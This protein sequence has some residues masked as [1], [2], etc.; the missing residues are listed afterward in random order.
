MQLLVDTDAFCKLAVG[1]VFV[2][3]IGLVGVS[4]AECGR[5]APLPHMLR[6]GILRRNYGSLACD[7]LIPVAE[8]IP[9]A[10]QPTEA[11]LD[12]LVPIRAIDPGEAQIFAA[13]AESRLLVLSNDKRALRALKDV[14]GFADA[15]AG[16]IIVLEAILLALCDHLGV[17][18]LRRR[19]NELV[20][21]DKVVK[22]C[23]SID[24]P[25]PKAALLSYFNN[26]VAELAPLVLWNTHG[27]SAE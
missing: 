6:R 1:D 5:L 18:T 19:F 24:N 25:D 27:G 10:M 20:E 22:V 15:L 16:R 9:V 8:S 21:L 2:E 4:L 3:A 26:L 11:W 17:E 12:K 23:F 7:K 14:E 13:A